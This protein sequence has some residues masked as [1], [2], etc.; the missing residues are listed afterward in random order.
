MHS[1]LSLTRRPAAARAANGGWPIPIPTPEPSDG[2]SAWRRR[3]SQP[4]NNC[5]GINGGQSRGARPRGRASRPAIPVEDVVADTRTMHMQRWPAG[6]GSAERDRPTRFVD[7]PVLADGRGRETRAGHTRHPCPVKFLCHRC[8]CGRR[9]EARSTVAGGGDG[10]VGL[11]AGFCPR[12]P[13]GIPVGGHP[14]RPAVA[15]RLER[16]TRRLGRAALEHLRRTA[17]SRRP[18]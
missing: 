18:S 9:R 7:R 14:S 1:G 11:Y 8:V 10:R 5:K 13:C 2:R 12:A 16:S 6:P 15:G 17:A 4:R 3:T